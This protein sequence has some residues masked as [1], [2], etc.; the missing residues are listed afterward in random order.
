[1]RI[2]ST[3]STRVMRTW[4]NLCEVFLDGMDSDYIFMD[5]N[6]GQHKNPSV[7][8]FHERVDI[9][10]MDRRS[11]VPDYSYIEYVW[12]GLGSVTPVTEHPKN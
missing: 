8:E 10:C 7:N 11:R 4:K 3:H 12:D 6:V 1:M 9:H 2:L 5:D